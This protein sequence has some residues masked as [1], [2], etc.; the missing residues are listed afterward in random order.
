MGW[1]VVRVTGS[2]HH[3]R[4]PDKG[5]VVTGKAVRLNI[6]MDEGLVAAID[7]VTNNRSNF[8]AEAARRALAER[9]AD[10]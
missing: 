3:L 8:L 5:P 1:R 9:L 7:R 10:A 2:H 4:H 6:T